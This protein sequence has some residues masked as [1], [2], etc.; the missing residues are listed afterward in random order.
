MELPS[1][2]VRPLLYLLRPCGTAYPH[3]QSD[4]AEHAYIINSYPALAL[5]LHCP[6]TASACHY[7]QPLPAHLATSSTAASAAS[8]SVY[9]YAR[10]SSCV[11]RGDGMSVRCLINDGR[12]ASKQQRSRCTYAE[13]SHGAGAGGRPY[14]TVVAPTSNATCPYPRRTLSPAPRRA[15]VPRQH[16]CRHPLRRQCYCHPASAAAAAAPAAAVPPAGPPAA[17]A[18]P[19]AE[20]CTI[21]G[22]WDVSNRELT[23]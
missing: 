3:E 14:R 1:R 23:E 10:S 7:C 4:R 5:P 12:C 16:H 8:R 15:A 21:G 18:A 13:D 19:P 9:S 17:A 6:C 2:F 22:A 20:V 11:W